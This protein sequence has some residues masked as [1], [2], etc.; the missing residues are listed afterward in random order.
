MESNKGICEYFFQ[1]EIPFVMITN[2]HLKSHGNG[3]FEANVLEYV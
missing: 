2:A 3:Y 1:L